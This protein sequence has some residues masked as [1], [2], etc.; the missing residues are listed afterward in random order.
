MLLVLLLCRA[1]HFELQDGD[2]LWRIFARVRV[3][4]DDAMHSRL[5]AN[6]KRKGKL[7]ILT[8]GRTPDLQHAAIQ[9]LDRHGLADETLR[10][11][12][13]NVG[14]CARIHRDRLKASRAAAVV[15]NDLLTIVGDFVR[16][17]HLSSCYAAAAKPEENGR[18]QVKQYSFHVCCSFR[19]FMG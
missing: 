1:R 10:K 8:D 7:T 4:Y 13:G 5:I 3:K 9:R 14:T 12:Q 11:L 19:G 16:L 6:L 18:H 15:L 17:R 2:D